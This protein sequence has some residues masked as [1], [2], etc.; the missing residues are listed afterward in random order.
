VTTK[1]KA[2]V[3]AFD[4][5]RKGA[6][7]AAERWKKLEAEEGA[8]EQRLAKALGV[9]VAELSKNKGALLYH[10]DELLAVEAAYKAGRAKG[11]AALLEALFE[12]YDLGYESGVD[13]GSMPK[14]SGGS[15]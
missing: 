7:E 10:G 12:F 3:L 6:A 14:R 13:D 15:K 1:S 4:R 8:N 5:D 9:T 11:R 2:L